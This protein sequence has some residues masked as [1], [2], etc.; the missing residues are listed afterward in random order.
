MN[1]VVI[2]TTKKGS[3]DILRE[4]ARGEHMSIRVTQ[5]KMRMVSGFLRVS[6][7]YGFV[8]LEKATAIELAESG[9]IF[10][11]KAWE[12]ITGKPCQ[13]QVIETTTKPEFGNPDPKINPD[14]GVVLKTAEGKEIYRTT[15]VTQNMEA[16][17]VYLEYVNVPAGGTGASSA[18]TEQKRV[19]EQ[20]D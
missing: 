6:N 14:T 20:F 2:T 12:E 5:K 3:K 17:D 15:N 11:G 16:E 19:G 9:M 10:E 4:S 7:V 13:I 8:T 1:K 18:E